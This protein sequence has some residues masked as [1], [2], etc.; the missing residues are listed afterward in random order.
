MLKP[1][2][3]LLAL[4]VAVPTALWGFAGAWALLALV[5]AFILAASAAHWRRPQGDGGR[6]RPGVLVMGG[7]FGLLTGTFAVLAMWAAVA[8]EEIVIHEEITVPAGPPLVW[9]TLG[10]PKQRVA[11]NTWIHGVEEMGKGGPAAVGSAY[12][13]DLFLERGTI[14]HKVVVTTFSPERAFGWTITPMTGASQLEDMR[15]DITLT[16]SP[17]G[18]TLVAVDL[19]YRVRS[20]LARIGELV[21]IRRSIEKVLE[22][23]LIRLAEEVAK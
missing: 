17:A 18:G 1:F 3:A 8:P 23:S 7:V 6:V 14:P 13:V 9:R 19:R 10:E 20:V 12:R 15:E 16:A 5:P 4:L 2:L 22:A 21:V 11:W